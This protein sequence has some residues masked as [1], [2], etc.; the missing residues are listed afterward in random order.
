MNLIKSTSLLLSAIHTANAGLRGNDR[1][2]NEVIY[3]TEYE[4][5]TCGN[6]KAKIWGPGGPHT[7]LLPAAELFNKANEGNISSE[8]EVCFGPEH[9]WREQ[10]LE[11]GGG[12]M[13][14][15]EQQ[16]AGMARVYEDILDTSSAR[17]ADLATPLTMH[18][19][20]IITSK[21]NPKGIKSL[22]D[23]LDRDDI[24]MVTV[25]GNYHDTLTSGTALWEDVIGRTGSLKDTIDL[26][27]KICYVASGA[28][29]A[30]NQLLEPEKT[31]CDAWIYWSDWIDA[32]P[33]LFEEV[34]L[35]PE[36]VVYRDL[37]VMPTTNPDGKIIQEFISYVQSSEEA[38][39]I[40]NQAG[41]CTDCTTKETGLEAK[42]YQQVAQTD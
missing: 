20:T 29:D 23:I 21:G 30:R 12:L 39:L 24:G 11:C 9:T 37:A 7:A 6:G 17:Y 19:A 41:W 31:G 32:N 40:M 1:M 35:D 28:G 14:A 5:C 42:V 33:D 25:D 3:S 2:Y 34:E 15:A 16:L 10:A 4:A 13:S 27:N 26:R 8:V 38:N 36:L 22:A 18:G